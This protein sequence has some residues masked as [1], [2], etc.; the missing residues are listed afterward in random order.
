MGPR[1]F[2]EV[3]PPLPGRITSLP[4]WEGVRDKNW[5]D[6][7]AMQARETDS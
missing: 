5:K 6:G 3:A 4:A 1:S 7:C 2:G